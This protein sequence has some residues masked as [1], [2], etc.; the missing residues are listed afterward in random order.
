MQFI[1]QLVRLAEVWSATD[2]RSLARLSTIVADNGRFFGQLNRPGSTCTVATF[3]KFLSF[4]R[5]PANWP[6]GDIPGD[7][8][9]LLGN[10]ANIA[11]GEAGTSGKSDDF[12]GAVEA[13][14]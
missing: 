1:D 14:E 3:E 7:A 8:A 13:A 10:F 5:D 6:G 4:F 12:T 9:D 11:T 2:G